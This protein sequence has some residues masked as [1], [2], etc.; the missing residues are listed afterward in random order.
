VVPVQVTVAASNSA[1]SP[2]APAV[3]TIEV[4]PKQVNL[5]VV[6]RGMLS[7]ARVSVAVSNVSQAIAEVS[8]KGAPRWLLVKPASFQLAPGE[9]QDVEL[10]GR[11]DKVQGRG[12]RIQLVFAVRGGRNREVQ[13]RLQI[14]R[15]GLL[16][17]MK[18]GG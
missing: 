6:D 12:Q 7:T 15:S 9:R 8:V 10:V 18:N 4:S 5:G 11:V 13:V 1:S 16:G 2:G 3:P 17:W 14:K